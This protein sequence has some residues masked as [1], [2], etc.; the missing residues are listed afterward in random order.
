MYKAI[1]RGYNP[2]YNGFLVSCCRHPGEYFL[3]FHGVWMLCF[4]GESSHTE[5]TSVSVFNNAYYLVSRCLN[6]QTP[7][8]KV[9]R[10]SKHL[11][12]RYLE[13][14]GCL[15]GNTIDFF[16]QQMSISLGGRVFQESPNNIG[17]KTHNK[18]SNEILLMVQKSG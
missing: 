10:V 4:G 15:G 11:L 17:A 1:Y 5:R 8:E 12:T 9:F 16:C 2:I 3:R 18:N 6:P 13:D 14:F 7:P